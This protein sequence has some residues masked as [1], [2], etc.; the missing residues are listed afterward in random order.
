MSNNYTLGRGKIYFSKFR[1]DGVTAAGFRYLGNTP[2]CSFSIQAENLDHFSADEGIKEKDESVALSTTRTGQFSTDNID[3]ANLAFFFFGVDDVLAVSAATV[4]AESLGAVKPGYS[5]QIGATDSVP[6]GQTN[7][8]IHTAPSTK[9][10]LKDATDTTTYDEGDDYTVDLNT[11]LVT[12][13][14]GGAISD[15]DVVHVTY[16]TTAQ[17]VE[18]VVSGSTPIEGAMRFISTNP[19]GKLFDY[20]MP[21]VKITPNGDFA[22]KGDTWQVIPFNLEILKQSNREAF[23]VSS[24]VAPA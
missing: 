12:I 19:K 18:R 20:F 14:E 2:E 8:T 4:T 15:G 9:I 10:I 21:W 5:Y 24:R 3:P 1:D 17:S 6:Q 13:V 7:L 22:L 23:Y 16:K 11:G